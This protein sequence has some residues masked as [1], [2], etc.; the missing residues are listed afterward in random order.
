MKFYKLIK[1]D[2][3]NGI[4]RKKYMYFAAFLMCLIFVIT[5]CYEVCAYKLSIVGERKTF[6]ITNIL[7]YFFQGKEPFSPELGNAFVFPVIWLII[8]LFSACITLDY[9]FRNLTGHGI[10]VLTRVRSRIY[11][12]FSKCIFVFLS[13]VFYFG[14]WYFT[15]WLFCRIVGIDVSLHFSEYVNLKLFNMELGTVTKEQIVMLVIIL[16]IL[17]ALAINFIQ[18]CLGLLMD[19]IYCF[20]ITAFLL[21]SSTYFQTPLAIGNFAMIKRSAL[22]ADG[23]MTIRC[24]ILMNVVLIT[25]CII[26]GTVR[27]K[28]YDIIKKNS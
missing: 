27:I 17:T 18:L 19:R 22:C 14:I 9:P 3:R 21:F 28:K 25:L 15:T 7:F 16:P 11:W 26:V 6:T 10:Y 24:G 8:F 12:W 2:I 5:F 1:Y 13:T 20:L 23:E 4:G